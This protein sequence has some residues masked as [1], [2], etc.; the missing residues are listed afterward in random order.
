MKRQK[1]R[2]K[3]LT[4]LAISSMTSSVIGVVSC[5]PNSS[6][7][8]SDNSSKKI[9]SI[10][11]DLGLATEPINNLNYVRYKSVDKILPSLVDSFIKDG[12]DNTLKR[13]IKTNPFTMLMV[14]TSKT[15]NDQNEISSSFDDFW[16]QKNDL[17]QEDGFGLTTTSYFD[18]TNFNLVGGLGKATST[19][20]VVKTSTIYAFRNPKNSSNYMALTGFLNNKLNRWSNGDYI[21]AQ[22]LRDYFEYILDLNTG[23]QKLDQILKFGIRGAEKFINAQ[24][25][26][27]AKYNKNYINP[28]GRRRYIQNSFGEYVQDPNQLVWQ[29]QIK[30]ENGNYIDQEDVDKIKEAALSFGFYTGQI[31]L[32]YTN[33]LIE[34]NLVHNPGFSLDKDIQE[35]I[36]QKNGVKK[37]VTLK[38]NEF[39]NPYQD[40][41]IEGSKIVSTYNQ[42]SNS[43]NSFS[44]IFDANKTPNLVFLVSHIITNIYPINRK[45]V[46][47]VAEGIDKYGSDPKLF[48]T[49]GPFLMDPSDV[50]LGPQGQIVLTKNNEYFDAKSTISNKIKIYFSSDRNINTTFFEDGYIS[51]TYIP[52]TK[53][54]KYWSNKDYKGYLNKNSGYGT[55]AYG[56]NLDNETNG[57]SYLQDQDLRNAMYF[58]INRENIIKFV[59]WDFSFP[60]NTFTSYGQYKTENGRNIETYFSD[61][62]SKTKDNK[63]YP[64]QNYDFV[65]HL[66]KSFT[67]EKTVRKDIAYNLETAKFYMNKFKAKYPGLKKVSLRYLNNSSDEQKNAGLFLREALQVAFGDFIDLELKSL[68]ENTFAAFIEEGQYDIIYQNYD[69]IGGNGA[70]DYVSTFFK[71]DGIDSLSQKTI[72]F[73]NNPVGSFVYSD[74]IIDLLLEKQGLNN[75]LETFVSLLNEQINSIKNQINT[76]AQE[77]F[78]KATTNTEINTFVKKYSKVF[79][80]NLG[81]LYTNDFVSYILEYLL[82]KN[83]N[84]KFSKVK[85]AYK[86]YV[87]NTMS[88]DEIAERTKETKERLNIQQSIQSSDKLSFDFWKKFIELSFIKN[89]ESLTEY[90]DRLSAFFSSNFTTSE[91]KEGWT[92]E[93]IYVFIGELEKIVRDGAFIIP[94]MEVDT[95]WEITRVGGTDSLYRFSLQ[96]AYDY[97]RP[98]R[99]GLPRGKER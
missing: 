63:E 57:D 82:V 22:D 43:E 53:I 3:L 83:S 4:L 41:N 99:P 67:F 39:L 7:T 13:L 73:K 40:F 12:P 20:D 74:Y 38:K 24:K 91:F 33:E 37:S 14:D 72:G 95:N 93:Y 36:I 81:A 51:Q 56:F 27:L 58:A 90:S 18:L 45:Y 17:A 30:G 26:Y 87:F 15:V 94:L 44:M 66:A 52:A 77:E 78:K 62:S 48:L 2:K 85:N 49:S 97:T 34:E 96:Y 21:N 68:P 84:I 9:T 69:K 35:F 71:N 86:R 32:D 50:V 75:N 1:I 6:V 23:S 80:E 47:T 28:F 25:E 60:V 5:A 61:L 92:Q 11:Y 65:V 8:D 70:D 55:I 54:N 76:N 46:E 10:D 64:L 16:K 31:F 59:G 98:P 89:N 88:I 79:A 19:S 42:I 29:P